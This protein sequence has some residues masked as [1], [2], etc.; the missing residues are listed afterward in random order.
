MSKELPYIKNYTQNL[1]DSFIFDDG[2][3]FND[4]D[5]YQKFDK[6]N[7]DQNK[8]RFMDLED[9]Y[10]NFDTSFKEVFK[11]N[12]NYNEDNLTNIK[13]K[14]T[15]ITNVTKNNNEKN[16]SLEE[17]E[18][19][20]NNRI[21]TNPFSEGNINTYINHPKGD[22]DSNFNINFELDQNNINNT[23]VKN[24]V[25][26]LKKKRKQT[27][28]NKKSDIKIEEILEEIKNYF[29]EY[30]NKYKKKQEFIPSYAIYEQINDSFEKVLTIVENNIP[31]CCIYYNKSFIS[32]I[33][34]IRE[35]KYLN[36]KKDIIWIFE[37]I[38]N[39]ILEIIQ[40]SK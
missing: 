29:N 37:R 13:T 26:L 11:I 6:L 34:L 23:N 31:G 36:D 4:T 27:K 35:E 21:F 25:H 28:E 38:K 10:N 19:K 24:D 30:N 32:K 16:I 15:T 22:D 3:M 2:N 1:N 40:N 7:I 9:K 12:N 5:S 33:Y 20:I 39:N 14:C 18:D 8:T 17:D